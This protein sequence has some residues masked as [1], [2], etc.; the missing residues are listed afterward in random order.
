MATVKHI[1]CCRS[2]WAS[3]RPFRASILH[4][5]P[6]ILRWLHAPPQLLRRDAQGA[7]TAFRQQ[8]QIDCLTPGNTNC[9]PTTTGT[10]CGD[11]GFADAGYFGEGDG[12]LS[13]AQDEE[14]DWQV[15]AGGPTPPGNGVGGT[16]PT[17]TNPTDYWN[18][19]VNEPG[20]PFPFVKSPCLDADGYAAVFL[21]TGVNA[22]LELDDGNLAESN[23]LAQAALLDVNAAV[24]THGW[25]GGGGVSGGVPETV[26]VELPPLCAQTYDAGPN[27]V[28]EG[29][30]GDDVI[31]TYPCP[32][33][34]CGN[35]AGFASVAANGGP[36]AGP[37][38][39]LT[40]F[41]GGVPT[42]PSI[43]TTNPAGPFVN[44]AYADLKVNLIIPGLKAV[45]DHLDFGTALK[46]VT[47]CGKV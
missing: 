8:T 22:V 45:C 18:P 41:T 15:T 47:L 27:G 44:G 11:D 34:I 13:A 36:G 5:F 35:P 33:Q 23:G 2:S 40:C 4:D 25:V 24:P 14:E 28:N 9:P 46:S 7:C 16:D 10:A 12:H 43:T 37:V 17:N 26:V 31:V 20:V 6:N 1:S 32:P 19:G 38:G 21:F 29:G 30:V 42:G 3:P 39:R